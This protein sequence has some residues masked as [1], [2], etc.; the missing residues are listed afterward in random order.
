MYMCAY[1]NVSTA[2]HCARMGVGLRAGKPLTLPQAR[3]RTS[4]KGQLSEAPTAEPR[5]TYTHTRAWIDRYKQTARI[6]T[7]T[8]TRRQ[9]S[10]F[11]DAEGTG[12]D[13]PYCVYVVSLCDEMRIVAALSRFAHEVNAAGGIDRAVIETI[14]RHAQELGISD[15]LATVLRAAG[16]SAAAAAEDGNSDLFNT[17]R[18]SALMVVGA[19]ISV[20]E[21]ALEAV[22]KTAKITA[23]VA[24]QTAKQGAK[25]MRAA[26]NATRKVA[27]SARSAHNSIRGGAQRMHTKVQAF[28]D[29]TRAYTDNVRARYGPSGEAA[30]VP[31]RLSLRAPKAALPTQKLAPLPTQKLAPPKAAPQPATAAE[32]GAPAPVAQYG[33]LA[34][35]VGRPGSLDDSVIRQYAIMQNA[36]FRGLDTEQGNS[37]RQ[38]IAGLRLMHARNFFVH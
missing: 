25:M 37:L 6:H 18:T 35:M 33:R 5:Q 13:A 26:A 20:I 14:H 17:N 10:N 29:R 12:D 27:S 4:T 2:A 21:S 7:Y 38:Y 15:D 34:E 22:G 30:P 16:R 8:G 24:S 28:A 19:V 9:M 23:Q 36:T 1:E 11:N 31:T 32:Q 3:S